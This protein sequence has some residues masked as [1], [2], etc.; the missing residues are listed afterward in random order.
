MF[1]AQ[2]TR[3]KSEIY[4][5]A[6]RECSLRRGFAKRDW[7]RKTRDEDGC[8]GG[9]QCVTKSSADLTVRSMRPIWSN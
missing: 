6:F 5:E 7:S 1:G 9:L 4:F 8:H 2:Q 3:L